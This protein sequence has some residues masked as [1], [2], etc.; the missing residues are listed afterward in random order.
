MKTLCGTS[1]LLPANYF[2][3]KMCFVPCSVL[4]GYDDHVVCFLGGVGRGP[5]RP[6]LPSWHRAW[7]DFCFLPYLPGNGKKLRFIHNKALSFSPLQCSL[8]CDNRLRRCDQ[9]PW[10]FYVTRLL[11]GVMIVS[12]RQMI[13]CNGRSFIWDEYCISGIII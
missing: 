11:C 13:Q 8:N 7:V 6:S 3:K 1:P 9:A 5:P 10:S 12:N 2:D 4:K